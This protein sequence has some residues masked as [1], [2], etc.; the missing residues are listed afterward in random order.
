MKVLQELQGKR[1][2]HFST[3]I[4]EFE[5]LARQRVASLPAM[6]IEDP[7]EKHIAWRG[8]Q[9]CCSHG[10]HLWLSTLPEGMVFPVNIVLN[11]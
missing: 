1:M 7:I 6:K 5:A 2:G 11:N 4:H 10:G 9:L 3:I 8:M